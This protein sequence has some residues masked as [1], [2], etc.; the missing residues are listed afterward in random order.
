[1]TSF[2]YSLR[3]NTSSGIRLKIEP[4][5][6]GISTAVTQYKVTDDSGMMWIIGTREECEEYLMCSRIFTKKRHDIQGID[7]NRGM[8]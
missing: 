3:D 4:V 2:L 5:F 7:E 6:D 8:G 1:M